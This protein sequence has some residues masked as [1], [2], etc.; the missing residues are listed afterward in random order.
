MTL[1]ARGHGRRAGQPERG[2]GGARALRA[3]PST[4]AARRSPIPGTRE[5][6]PPLK[7][8]GIYGY[9]RAAL[10]RLAELAPTPLERGRVAGA[11]PGAGKRHCRSACCRSRRPL[12]AST[13]RKTWSGSNDSSQGPD[14]DPGETDP[15]RPS[16]SSSPAAS[17]RRSARESPPPPSARS[18]ENRGF[19]GHAA[20]VR[21]LH[22]RRSG[23][24]VALPARRGLRHRRRRARPTSTSATTSASPHTVTHAS[25]TTT[26]PGKIYHT[27]IN[28]ERRGDYLG[29]TVQVIPHITDEIKDAIR[30]GAAELRRGDRRDRRHR[31]RHRVAAVPRGH[32]PVPPGSS[33]ATTRSTS[34]SPW[35]PTSRRRAS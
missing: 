31:R 28:K 2:Q 8:L 14:E 1:A 21:S 32:P 16:T 5:A 27:V 26:P 20:E 3:T 17:S 25:D 30:R 18:S 35:S 6:P 34:T 12:R 23:H 9:Q 22:Q 33:A 11:A 19:S 24:H 13:P 7:H 4:S 29:K 10:L 15:W